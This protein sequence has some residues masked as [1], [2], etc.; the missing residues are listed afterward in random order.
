[1][2]SSKFEQTVSALYDAALDPAGWHVA[3]SP[4]ADLFA[5]PTIAL[6][7]TEEHSGR[8]I[9]IFQH[10]HDPAAQR[11][12]AGRYYAL[13]PTLIHA[14]R[15]LP[16]DWLGPGVDL[17]NP[18]SPAN[19]EYV[20]DYCRPHDIRWIAGA[21]LHDAVGVHAFL[22][23]QRPSG[24]AAF[25]SEAESLF[26]R[27]EPHLSRVLAIRQRLGESAERLSLAQ[28]A[29]DQMAHAVFVVASGLQ[30][31]FL[32]GAAEQ[33]MRTHGSAMSSRHLRLRLK[34]G[35]AH[36][37]LA[38]AVA[39]ACAEAGA[40]DAFVASVDGRTLQVHV[41]PMRPPAAPGWGLVRPLALI[42]VA[43]PATT[44]HTPATLARLF[45]LSTAEARLLAA[46]EQGMS[47]A[48][49]AALRS[50]GMPTLRTQLSAIFQKTGVNSQMQLVALARA[51]PGLRDGG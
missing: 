17:L 31:R 35:P 7:R 33:L 14:A 16:G 32:N 12:Y 10:G 4:L 34:D 50:V 6:M 45:D 8:P 19:A 22:S 27:L 46:L 21:R 36:D 29:V 38:R 44:G 24:M 15:A 3:L 11:D 25:G 23:V 18:R 43:D 37:R 39:A 47:L 30:I 49:Y 26:R 48:E 51:L 20:N 1:M 42:L 13:D 41:S 5:A 2:D 9:E 40:G 28:A